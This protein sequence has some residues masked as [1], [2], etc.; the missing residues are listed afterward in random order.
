MQIL[1]GNTLKSENQIIDILQKAIV[2]EVVTAP[3]A[4]ILY[5]QA[6]LGHLM[7]TAH[8]LRLQKTEQQYVGWIIDRNVNITN[9][10]F[11]QC[12]FCNFC[13][14]PGSEKEYVTTIEE[15]TQKINEMFKLGGNQLLLQGGMHPKLDLK[16]YT[17][18][19]S[20]LKNLFPQL[21]LHALG[22]AEVHFLA[23][24]ARM[25]YTNVLKELI[26]SGLDSLPGAGAEILNDRVRNNISPRKCTTNQWLDVMR[27]AH[28]LGLVTSATM[29]FGH[30]ETIEERIEHLIHIRTIQDEKPDN[31]PGF[32]TF[33][34][35]PI[36]LE[37][38]ALLKQ[39]PNL[40]PVMSSEYLRMIAISRI[41][42]H[43][44][45]NLQASLLT[46]GPNVAMASL[47]AGANDLGSIMIEENV[48]SSAGV[49]RT[50][51]KNTITDTIRTAGF[52][53]RLRNQAYEWDEDLS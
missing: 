10:C 13:V 20:S 9:G 45:Q 34:P 11:S 19:F 41:V 5:K 29:M 43:N 46:V 30:L 32:A 1:K 16:Y 22:P 48:V 47:Y 53:P 38:T 33:I 18:L 24:K 40:K 52:T 4:S 35:W 39:H 51:E 23:Q 50:I 6:S 44:I 17:D 8:T 36:M 37:N 15:Y 21:K 42:L 3:E 31:T 49:R 28:N 14:V 12:T 25:S 27:A 26:D 2:G 7:H